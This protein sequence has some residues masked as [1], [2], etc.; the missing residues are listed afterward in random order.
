MGELIDVGR[1]GIRLAL[2]HG[3]PDDEVVQLVFPRKSDNKRPEGRMIIG[4]VVQSKP[5]VGRHIVTIAFG[6]D[7]ALGANSRPVRKDA[8]SPSFFRPLS[9]KFRAFV[10]SAWN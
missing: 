10:A 5:D 2:P 4:R 3:L 1:G 9:K 6:W 8:K 7:A